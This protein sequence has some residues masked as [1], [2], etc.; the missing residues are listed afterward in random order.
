MSN[1]AAT[2]HIDT[3]RDPRVEPILKS[4]ARFR[5]M[6]WGRGQRK[7]GYATLADLIKCVAGG[8]YFRGC[9][10]GPTYE[11]AEETVYIAETFYPQLGIHYNAGK[12][13][14]NVLGGGII[15]VRS[16]THP[17]IIRGRQYDFV[18]V[19][20]A[21]YIKD[22][23]WQHVIRGT[24][25]AKQAPA[26]IEGTPY[27]ATWGGWYHTLCQRG[28]DP[29]DTEVEIFHSTPAQAPHLAAEEIETLR[30]SL[31]GR[32][33]RQEILAEWLPGGGIVFEHI[34]IEDYELAK[35]SGG[36]VMGVDVAK[37]EDYTVLTVLDSKGRVCYFHRM[38]KMEY[39]KQVEFIAHWAKKFKAAVYLDA[40]G[41]GQAILDMLN[42]CYDNV[43]PITFTRESKRQLVENLVLAFEKQEI[44]IPACLETLV[45][46]LR[47]YAVK[48]RSTG[49]QYGAPPGL[50]D[51]CVMS[52][53]LA[54]WGSG[55]ETREYVF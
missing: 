41:V 44:I 31:P 37:I 43:I 6:H 8:P 35:P 52:L 22:Y 46:E 28:D 47:G 4:K 18:H 36:C 34:P 2:I 32:V 21:A 24:M 50:H 51:D 54:A 5:I 55:Q 40:T 20:E 23:D 16:T 14:M 26:V 15:Y 49:L 33:F 38:N 12:H 10:I 7:T 27:S 1:A 48:V 19:L 53:A 25:I 3:T 29:R 45:Q 17:D 11:Q 13:Y 39:P 9:I 30:T 42:E